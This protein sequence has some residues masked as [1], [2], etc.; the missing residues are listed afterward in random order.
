VSQTSERSAGPVG[1]ELLLFGRAALQL[2]GAALQVPVRKL[3][4]LIAFLA[5]EGS[6]SR[7]KLA[8]LLWSELNEA[9]ARR[10]LRQRLYRLSPPELT[11]FVLVEGDLVSLA[12]QVSSDV[13][14]FERAMLEF[15]FARAV[16]LYRG[17]LL[18]GLE[19][20]EASA[21]DEWLDLKR[22]GFERAFQRALA[23]LADQLETAGLR[24]QSL[25]QHLRLIE[26]NPLLELHQRHVMRLRGLSGERAEA[27]SGFERFRDLLES[28]LGLEPMPETLRL[29]EQIR[30]QDTLEARAIRTA[31][32]VLPAKAPAIG[33]QTL[34]GRRAVLD[35]LEA[36]WESDQIV[37]IGGEPGIGKS[38]LLQ[39]FAAERNVILAQGR[40]GD[41]TIPYA[42]QT[43][44]IRRLLE[45]NP[46]VALPRW[47]RQE[48]SRLIPSLDETPAPG[49]PEARIRLFDAVAEF[50]ALTT[51]TA[52]TY[53]IDDLQFFD[54]ESFEMGMHVFASLAERGQGKRLLMA[55][56]TGELSNAMA[57]VL[58]QKFT[59]SSGAHAVQ[60]DL[61]PLDEL[62]LRELVQDLFGSPEPVL[63]ARRLHNATGGNPFF[64]LETL[65][66]LVESN[67]LQQ[68]ERGEWSTPFDETTQAYAELSMPESVIAAVRERVARLGVEA[69]RLLETASLAGDAFRLED[70][71]AATTLTEFEALEAFERALELRLL[72]R[73]DG[74]L[75]GRLDGRQ[76]GRSTDTYRFS[77]DLVREA[78]AIGLGDE[79]KRLLHRKLAESLER[80]AGPATRIAEHLER[81]GQR[82]AAV[83]WRVKAA[84]SAMQVYATREAINEYELA[85]EDEPG[86][87]LE[88][89]EILDEMVVLLWRQNEFERA[90]AWAQELAAIRETNGDQ[91]GLARAEIVIGVLE[92]SLGF[93]QPALASF[94]RALERAR[95]INNTDLQARTLINLAKLH[96]DIGDVQSAWPVVN[97]GLALGDA[98]SLD[99]Q[100]MFE[101]AQAY[102]AL[103]D[104]DLGLA[105]RLVPASI[106]KAET[107]GIP[108]AQCNA[109]LLAFDVYLGVGAVAVA[110]ALLE[111]LETLIQKHDF[112]YHRA[113]YAIK[114][115]W[116]ELEQQRP[117]L[118]L[119]AIS[120]LADDAAQ[121]EDQASVAW[122]MAAS[123]LQLHQPLAALEVLQ[124]FNDAPTLEVWARLL[125][126]RL[127]AG[128]EAGTDLPDS[129]RADLIIAAQQQ[130]E[131]ERTPALEGLGLRRA[132][133][134]ALEHSGESGAALEVRR[135]AASRLRAMAVTL[136]AQPELRRCL[137]EKFQALT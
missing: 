59:A 2:N 49:G 125:T 76:D 122:I 134:L 54:L 12:G 60:I 24:D 75:D 48:L 68:N 86:A 135:V 128:L 126:V 15:D 28:E 130:L 72:E 117:S 33:R 81:A 29:V 90:V 91:S 98:I 132:L 123:H 18:D 50:M 84:K 70:V 31:I 118:A 106:R 137:L 97:A 26:I 104:G 11:G 64:A 114:R 34:I 124:D 61:E 25:R 110:A 105:A 129:V 93:R 102:C 131:S 69:T 108:Y 51:R 65:K 40:A 88:R 80:H 136:E 37:L 38:R 43:R 112:G 92:M 121:P 100:A 116:L 44:V 57:A 74:R 41:A 109:M 101:A 9:D 45:Q 78:L 7:S 8:G 62:A 27:V 96:T 95:S 14:E 89:A 1:L 71:Q 39:E 53:I 66:S 6:S 21:F 47:V 87:N 46:Q 127:Q 10:N 103:L 115:A 23:G 119:E 32:Q 94:E 22:D 55:Y 3:V 35:Q 17:P 58:E 20:E 5:L 83:S 42:T 85:L 77:H 13:T 73:Q 113:E 19:L 120:G 107:S 30:R 63:F 4:G 36:A 99:E 79:R 52:D 111:E 16:A 133:A 82:Q 67:A 56:R